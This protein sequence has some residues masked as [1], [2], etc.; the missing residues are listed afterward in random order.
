MARY[1][2]FTASRNVVNLT[3]LESILSDLKAMGMTEL[4]ALHNSLATA[5]GVATVTSFK[6]LGAARTAITNLQSKATPMTTETETETP[7]A[8]DGPEAAP[9]DGA[10]P[11][12]AAPVAAAP[13]PAADA[14]KYNST[15][16]RGPNQGV[17]AFAKE[18][19]L[20]GKNNADA[21]KAV[22]AK[23]PDAKTTTGCIAFYRTALSKNPVIDAAKLRADAAALLAKA[24][25]AEAAVK[26]KAEADA[27]A[28]ADK[29]TAE[30]AA[31]VAAA[32]PAAEPEAAPM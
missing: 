13:A 24:D 2:V 31:R 9:F 23:F 28:A 11:V 25:A 20:A 30:A 14:D 32:M 19:I 1:N 21:L 29:E 26:A 10:T 12:A 5:H 16:K 3:Y 7:V 17:G 15:G 4:I 6:S 27:K 22:L 8:A 18:Q